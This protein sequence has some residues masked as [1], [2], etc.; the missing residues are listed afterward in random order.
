MWICV[1]RQFGQSKTIACLLAI[2]TITN[3][4][5]AIYP[6]VPAVARHRHDDAAAI[7]VPRRRNREP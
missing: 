5:R 4:T 3:Y 1:D 2:T 7:W 6:T